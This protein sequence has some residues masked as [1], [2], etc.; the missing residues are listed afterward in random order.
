MSDQNQNLPDDSENIEPILDDDS[1]QLSSGSDFGSF[2][3]G[4]DD[5]ILED[6]PDELMDSPS[7]LES[8]IASS[9][10]SDYTP[11]VIEDTE[12]E[13]LSPVSSFE[14]GRNNEEDNQIEVDEHEDRVEK[15]ID[16]I[17]AES[18]SDD[19][20]FDP[21]YKSTFFD[22]EEDGPIFLSSDE[23]SEVVTDDLEVEHVEHDESEILDE[24]PVIENIHDEIEF[25]DDSKESIEE[26]SPILE[27]K[28]PETETKAEDEFGFDPNY[29]STFFDDEEDGPILLSTDE[30]SE[31]VSEDL[32]VE[33]HDESQTQ[34][35]ETDG[36]ED[37]SAG[38]DLDANLTEELSHDEKPHDPR[39]EFDF[40]PDHKSTFFDEEEDGPILLSSDE[41]SEVVAEDLPIEHVEDEISNTEEEPEDDDAPTTI[42]ANIL[43][44]IEATQTPEEDEEPVTLGSDVLDEISKDSEEITPEELEEEG[45]HSVDLAK[46]EKTEEALEPEID[47][48]EEEEEG[49]EDYKADIIADEDEIILFDEEE[50]EAGEMPSDLPSSDKLPESEPEEAISEIHEDDHHQEEPLEVQEVSDLSEHED[51]FHDASEVEIDL[52][53]ELSKEPFHAEEDHH[54]E[55]HHETPEPS[56]VPLIPSGESKKEIIIN[57]DEYADDGQLSPLEELRAMPKEEE[58]SSVSKDS[59]ETL[60]KDEMKKMMNYLDNLLGNLPED[61]IQEFSKSSYFELYKK[62]MSDIGI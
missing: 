49:L 12:P 4:L 60:S 39:D 32:S 59:P 34:K 8:L 18:T 24:E 19:F 3:T 52:H 45:K 20:G 56:D 41:L 35:P 33:H 31:V 42:D 58:E 30:L 13:E 48:P 40:D 61:M 22:E 26:P 2:H 28:T 57:L 46:D 54:D 23:L 16:Q 55:E 10:V 50:D 9:E 17:L 14:Y 51:P 43:D 11:V 7:S 6:E 47:S 62:L 53:D 44:E 1:F 29:K 21:N 27:E 37:L 36:L 5:F 38:I 25:H 15:L